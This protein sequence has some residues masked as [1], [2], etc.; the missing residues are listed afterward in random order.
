[1][2]EENLEQEMKTI[3]QTKY[4]PRG[5]MGG[6]GGKRT[7]AELNDQPGPFFALGLCLIVGW[8]VWEVGDWI[9]VMSKF[10]IIV[11]GLLILIALAQPRTS[12]LLAAFDRYIKANV[13]GIVYLGIIVALW[14]YW[15]AIAAVLV[16]V[17]H[18]GS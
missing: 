17:F 11:I 5:S 9:G 16:L 13:R 18:A 8:L 6:I 7:D 10:E 3:L 2:T 4:V 12:K 14:K 1:M 15:A